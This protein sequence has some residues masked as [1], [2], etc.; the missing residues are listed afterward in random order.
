MLAEVLAVVGRHDHQGLLQAAATSQ[1]VEE[2]AELF[3]E[4]GEA[5]IIGVA[6]HPEL[7]RRHRAL[8]PDEP[9]Q[10]D[11]AIGRTLRTP[12]EGTPKIAGRD[13]RIMGVIEVQ[14]GEERPVARP[15][16]QPAQQLVADRGGV[17]AVGHLVGVADAPVAG[18]QRPEDPAA[19]GRA[20]QDAHRREVLV[21]VMPEAPRQAGLGAGIRPVGD[22][23]RGRVPARRKILGQRGERPVERPAEI[24]AQFVRPSAGHEARVRGQGP[25]GGRPR[26]REPDTPG[27]EPLQVRARRPMI[28]VG[29]E[30]IGPHGVQHDQQDIRGGR[31]AAVGLDG[32]PPVA[33][34]RPQNDADTRAADRMPSTGSVRRTSDRNRGSLR[35]IRR[36]SR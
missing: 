33:T 20:P 14:E 1:L 17:L 9:L 11:E 31:G 34:T 16:V 15:I 4:V 25:R 3:V 19:Q 18:D 13:V 23:A 2:P 5:V 8:L 36:D 35:A 32:R 22:E 28:P 26:L 24:R 12:A 7:S 30:A 6:H 10:Q 27:G 29:A 21:F